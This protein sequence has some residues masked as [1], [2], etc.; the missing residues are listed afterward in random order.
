MTKSVAV[1]TPPPTRH[2]GQEA[3]EKR[4]LVVLACTVH[5]GKLAS[6][7]DTH[8]V[9]VMLHHLV[10]EKIGAVDGAFLAEQVQQGF[11]CWFNYK[12]MVAHAEEHACAVALSLAAG[13]SKLNGELRRKNLCEGA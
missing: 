1:I 5:I 10:A 3:V 8:T 11:T 13:V 6:M 7:E 9:T 2:A 12:T 4:H